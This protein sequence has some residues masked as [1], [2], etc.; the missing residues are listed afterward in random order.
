[1]RSGP[2]T[3][4]GIFAVAERGQAYVLLESSNGWDHVQVDRRTGW[5][6]S[7]GDEGLDL[8]AGA[9]APSFAATP[10]PVTNGSG[11]NATQA[12]IE[13]LARIVKGEASQCSFEGKVAVAA[14]VLNRVQA[15]GFPGTIAGVAHQPW[16]FSCYNANVRDRL[17]WG[18]IPQS[19]WDAARAA[20][21]GQDPSRGATYYFNPFLVKPSWAHTMHFLVR[22]GST[23]VTAHDFYRP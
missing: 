17:Y 19:C 12:D 9:P 8:G 13:I 10:A 20:V 6:A 1:M 11:V 16:Q 4:Y 14:V 2:S 7:F 23:A 15:N 21:A 5:I 3:G 18:P 22:I